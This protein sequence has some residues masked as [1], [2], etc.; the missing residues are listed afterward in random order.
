MEKNTVIT[1]KGDGGGGEGEE[2]SFGQF[3]EEEEL[4]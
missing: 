4:F 1:L 3:W 2:P